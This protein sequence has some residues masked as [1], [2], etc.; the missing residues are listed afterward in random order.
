MTLKNPLNLRG[1]HKKEIS[2]NPKLHVGL[3]LFSSVPT[4]TAAASVEDIHF[5]SSY[6]DS[7]LSKNSCQ[8]FA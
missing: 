1:R 7:K 4:F 5:I 3:V 2:P 8:T 6:F